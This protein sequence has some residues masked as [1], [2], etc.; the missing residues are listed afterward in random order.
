MGSLNDFWNT[1]SRA[2][3]FLETGIVN[4]TVRNEVNSDGTPANTPATPAPP[5]CTSTSQCAAG[6]ACVN[7]KCTFMGQG[8]GSGQQP[9]PGAGGDC[10]PQ[11]PNSACNQGG[12]G[13]CQ[14]E[15]DPCIG[16]E[17]AEEGK[18]CC[19]TRCCSFGSASSSRPGVHCFCGE[20]PPWPGCTSFCD[21]Y[22]KTWG[23]PGPGCDE[24][25]GGNSCNSCTYCD[26]N[27]GGE[28]KRIK[29][30]QPC[31]CAESNCKGPCERCETEDKPFEGQYLGDCRY[32]PDTTGCSTCAT[33]L[34]HKCPKCPVIIPEERVCVSVSSGQNP[35]QLLNQKL[36]KICE[37]ACKVDKPCECPN[38][39][40]ACKQCECNCNTECG[41]CK[42]CNGNCE[43]VDD[44]ACDPP[45]CPSG[46]QPNPNGPWN[47]LFLVGFYQ[48][49]GPGSTRKRWYYGFHRDPAP[50]IV[51]SGPGNNFCSGAPGT[52][53]TVSGFIR[54][55]TY[56]NDPGV[57]DPNNF[58]SIPCTSF[59]D[60]F[61]SG[62]IT[63]D[64]Y[65]LIQEYSQP[66]SE[67]RAKCCDG[68][69]P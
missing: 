29:V 11:D 6:Y 64:C 33:T 68:L 27:V 55:Y 53:Q 41:P 10:D 16:A 49:A 38:P 18:N 65:E 58:G 31:W 12:V 14:Q 46:N 36:A 62:I 57:P 51:W 2:N 3:N 60:S 48:P 44:P 32:D 17:D 30:N 19:G 43:C 26:G 52:I 15:A 35:R 54:L 4:D 63:S 9:S 5:R 42:I 1:S 56:P 34:N 67:Q 37:E 61:Q 25:F 39:D 47:P 24:G 50:E 59:E 23:K 20:C 8:S 45:E 40:P 22:L 7:G 69:F 66:V 21:S 28:C 13:A